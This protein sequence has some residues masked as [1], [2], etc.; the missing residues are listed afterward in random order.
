MRTANFANGTSIVG[1]GY[2][3]I[4]KI[5]MKSISVAL[6]SGDEVDGLFAHVALEFITNWHNLC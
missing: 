3:K 2:R 4:T 5:Q 1:Q 6:S